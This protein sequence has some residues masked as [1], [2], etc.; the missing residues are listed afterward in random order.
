MKS[1]FSMFV[2]QVKKQ[3]RITGIV[4]KEFLIVTGDGISTIE[5][6]I[7]QNPRYELQLQSLKKEYGNQLQEVLA[8]GEKRN[9]VP[10]GNHA[11]VQNS[12]MAAI[13]LR[14]N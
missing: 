3:D 12:L 7:K 8:K 14:Q 9:L 11:V 13:G 4:A 6:L 2:I 10:Y 5:A 1:E